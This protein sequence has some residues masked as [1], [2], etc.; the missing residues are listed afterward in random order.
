MHRNPCTRTIA[1]VDGSVSASNRVAG[2]VRSREERTWEK[3]KES[4]SNH[5]INDSGGKKGM[6]NASLV[7]PTSCPHHSVHVHT[8]TLPKVHW[9]WRGYACTGASQNHSKV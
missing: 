9:A 6:Q 1:H 3:R 7:L 4:P 5:S 8:N 2:G